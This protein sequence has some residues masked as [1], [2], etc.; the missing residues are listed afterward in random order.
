MKKKLLFL[1]LLIAFLL[2]I[3]VNAQT[4]DVSSETLLRAFLSTGGDLRLTSDITLSGEIQVN[5]DSTLDLNG[6]TID[7]GNNYFSVYANLNIK[8]SSSTVSGKITGSN[9]YIIR[10]GSSSEKGV[11]TLE[12][13]SID[14]SSKYYCVRSLSEGEIEINGGKI[15]GKYFPLVAGGKVTINDGLIEATQSVIYGNTDAEITMNGGLIKML[16]DYEAVLLSKPGSKFIMNGGRIEALYEEGYKGVAIGAFKDTEIIINDGEVLASSACIMGNGSI[17]GK[18]EGSNAKFTINGGSL[19]STLGLG[20]YAP[21]VNGETL[22]TGGTIK[23]KSSAI[24][25][26]AGKLT[27]TGGTLN[28]NEEKY[29]ITANDNGSN[30]VGSAISIIQ[31]TTKQPIEVN[32]SGGVFNAYLPLSESNPMNN[33][34]DD[35]SKIKLNISGGVFNSTG[36]K[37]VNLEDLSGDFITGGT[38]TH[39]VNEY[40]NDELYGERDNGNVSVTV[41]PYRKIRP[42]DEQYVDIVNVSK[43]LAGQIGIVNVPTKEDYLI[44]V[45]LKNADGEEIVID[46]NNKFIMPN[47]DITVYVNY[48]FLYRFL[49]GQDQTFKGNDLIIKTNGD[50]SKLLRIEVNATQLD[51][52]NYEI[53]RGST[54]LTLNK[55]YLSSL[56]NGTYNVKFVYSDGELNTSFIVDNNNNNKD[57]SNNEEANNHV[58]TNNPKTSD[59]ISFYKLTFLLSV[60][61]LV[62]TMLYSKKRRFNQNYSNFS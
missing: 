19:I 57:I 1:A 56:S 9:D 35:L 27:V 47:S 25:L 10:V 22:I 23:G 46:E 62:G 21:Q 53:K 58:D 39:N 54:I 12:S 44:D 5:S 2:P 33:S 60:S 43:L 42:E 50:I 36:S 6:Y 61:G 11:L 40:I 32:I 41:L 24:E 28:G 26:R 59:N 30:A 15:I 4:F 45:T 34:E 29:E 18:N 20:I 3:S 38:Y 16:T 14:C 7:T 31:H 55:K 52:S 49:E 48:K 51:K 37:T 8:D 13:G 17:D